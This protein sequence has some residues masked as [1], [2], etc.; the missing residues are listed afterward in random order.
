MVDAEVC[1]RV[2]SALYIIIDVFQMFSVSSTAAISAR[3]PLINV[4]Q[5]CKLLLMALL[6]RILLKSVPP[7]NRS[8]SG[9]ERCLRY[10]LELP[11]PDWVVGRA[12]LLPLLRQSR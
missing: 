9:Q 2:A 11:P 1:Q 8:C 5:Q 12:D 10:C 3:S 6:D 4:T 7:D